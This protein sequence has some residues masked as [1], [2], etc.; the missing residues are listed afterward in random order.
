MAP[1]GS[2][3]TGAEDLSTGLEFMVGAGRRT[4]V[5]DG[6]GGRGRAVSDIEGEAKFDRV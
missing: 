4:A 2:R 3:S 1:N 6:G 5:D